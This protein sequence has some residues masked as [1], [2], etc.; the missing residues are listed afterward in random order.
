MYLAPTQ[1]TFDEDPSYVIPS[2]N[3]ILPSSAKPTKADFYNLIRKKQESGNP[4]DIKPVR[5]LRLDE[6]T[7]L[8]S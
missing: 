6:D 5:K 8:I 4:E 3:P 7:D 2:K 1:S